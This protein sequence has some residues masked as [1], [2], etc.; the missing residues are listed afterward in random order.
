MRNTFALVLALSVASPIATPAQTP[1]AQT[2][3]VA[4]AQAGPPAP[5][6]APWAPPG[7]ENI[8]LERP[9]QP[10]QPNEVVR[11]DPDLD[12]LIAPGVVPEV[13]S[14]DFNAT[15]GPMWREGKLWVSDQRWGMIWAFDEKGARSLIVQD[16]GRRPD[17]AE[18]VNQGPN[19]QA[20]DRDGGVLVMRQGFRDIARMT[21][22]RKIT[23]YL[24]TFE[25]KRF[26]S[27]NDL[28]Y[29][30]DGTL[31][32]TDPA[33]S[34]PGGV[35]GPND[36]LHFDGVYSYKNG[37][38]Q[39]II[40]DLIRPNGIGV[41]PDGKTLFISTA[42]P[43][44]RIKAYDIQKDGTVANAR[45]FYVWPMAPGQRGGVDGLK[46]DSQ[47]NIW[48][49]GVGG[50]NVISRD[51]RNLG[52]VQVKGRAASNVAFGGRDGKTLYITGGHYLY[53]I[54]TLVKGQTPL[55][56]R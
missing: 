2:P 5:V 36:E 54:Q 23:A 49:T 47:G 44:P 7:Y 34:L 46:V 29:A 12:R 39:A 19:G 43:G 18:P 20:P 56:A 33:F 51:G 11:L 16:T 31:F 9:P 40:K 24:S 53:R 32:F 4:P 14:E 55:Y 13:V 37:K 22:D 15:E 10:I 52:R 21:P 6:F 45:D 38:L 26:N 25:G 48:A 30:P 35:N 28:V 8:S 27:P 50:V 3:P 41:S 42:S 17:P 1:P